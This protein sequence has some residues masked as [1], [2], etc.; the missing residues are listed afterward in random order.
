MPGKPGVELCYE[1]RLK[2]ETVG[3]YTEFCKF[4]TDELLKG[5]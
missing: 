5:F 4:C 2:P 3:K 1:N